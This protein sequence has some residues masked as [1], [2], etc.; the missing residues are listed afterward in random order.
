ML[1]AS[2]V[3]RSVILLHTFSDTFHFADVAVFSVPK[4]VLEGLRF[5][6]FEKT[7]EVLTE[8]IHDG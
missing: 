6:L 8:L 1:G 4:P 3:N 7:H 2:R 5:A